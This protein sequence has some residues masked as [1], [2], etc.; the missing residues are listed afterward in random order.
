MSQIFHSNDLYLIQRCWYAEI[1]ALKIEVGSFL[2]K[3]SEK[4]EDNI[5]LIK[6]GSI[7]V[8]SLVGI[9]MR[10]EDLLTELDNSHEVLSRY[11]STFPISSCNR[12]YKKH[13]Q[14]ESKIEID[15]EKYFEL[16]KKINVFLINTDQSVAKNN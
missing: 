9:N 8:N 3:L 5:L 13:F 16:R 2:T 14:L 12:S 15:K 4:L 7:L 1:S 6:N 11:P 10:F